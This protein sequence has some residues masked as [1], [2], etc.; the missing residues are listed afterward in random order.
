MSYISSAITKNDQVIVWERD[1]DDKRIEVYYDAPYYFYIDDP[2]G[3]HLTIYNTKVT[4]LVFDTGREF[5]TTRRSVSEMGVRL[6]ESDIPADLRVI[7]NE[8]YGQPSPKMHITF[9]DIENDY[10]TDQGYASIKNPYAPINA[11]SMFHTHRNELV[12]MSVPPPGQ[13][14]TEKQLYDRCNEI[15]P[16][17]AEYTTT[18]RLFKTEYEMLLAFLDDIEDS[19]IL[20]GW[21][22]QRFDIPYIG[23]RILHTLGEK[24]FKRLSFNNAPPPEWKDMTD[25]HQQIYEVLDISGRISFDYLE[26][27][28]KYEVEE[29]HSYKLAAIEEEVGLNLPKLE[30]EGTLHG[31]YHNDFGYFVR[32]NIRDSE[33]LRGFELVLGYVDVACQMYHLSGASPKH[34]QGTLKLAEYA[35]VN[36]CHKELNR[37]VPNITRPDIDRQI[38]GALVLWPQVGLH[39]FL[40]SIDINSLYPSAIRSINMSPETIVGQFL[41]F[42]DAQIAIS[43]GSDK[44]I[45]M[46]VEQRSSTPDQLETIIETKTAAE[47]KEILIDNKWAISGYGTVFDQKTPGII[48]TILT[49][50]FATRK[51]YQAELR[52][53]R[54]ELETL[55][56]KYK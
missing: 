17:P 29:R 43:E 23:K 6:W 2:D 19:D 18:I 39:E 51:Q 35:I 14:W 11:I 40:G 16:F 12:A 9:L 24:H 44:M 7:S 21:N 5:Y 36:Y 27:Y 22:S 41:E 53:K 56:S 52:A 1:K 10:N 26:L 54:K 37:V 31:L 46:Q 49:N 32:Y 38:D 50:W 28:R 25:N 34:V 42:E 8:Y 3:D 47:W 45:S 30:Y 55:L 15:E 13:N 33:I 4:K 48:P 20:V